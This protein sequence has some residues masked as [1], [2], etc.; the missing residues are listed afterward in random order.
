MEELIAKIEEI[1][2][3]IKSIDFGSANL[4][5]IT[6]LLFYGGKFIEIYKT[7][8]INAI[9]RPYMDRIEEYLLSRYE[10]INV[11]DFM[12]KK[13]KLISEPDL[14]IEFYLSRIESIIRD[15]YAER[16][17][18]YRSKFN[19]LKAIN[20]LYPKAS[21][22]TL[23]D[24]FKILMEDQLND[25]LTIQTKSILAYFIYMEHIEIIFESI[26]VHYGDFIN[27][28]DM[29]EIMENLRLK[30]R[31]H[32]FLREIQKKIV[33]NIQ[34]KIDNIDSSESVKE[35]CTNLKSK[36]NIEQFIKDFVLNTLNT[37]FSQ[38]QKVNEY[39]ENIDSEI[40]SFFESH[41]EF[42]EQSQPFF[43]KLESID[44]E[45]C[46]EADERAIAGENIDIIFPEICNLAIVKHKLDFSTFSKNMFLEYLMAEKSMV[47]FG[48]TLHKTEEALSKFFA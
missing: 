42:M 22:Q 1:V 45:I 34:S 24:S 28:S 39:F 20:D 27:R 32:T 38:K 17:Q 43:E 26:C 2:T 36:I 46:S 47:Q 37:P 29:E 9:F 4:L 25:Y 13:N 5:E 10:H 15:Q 7:Q 8:I 16:I 18:N 11:S 31:E 44:D 23:L 35:R 19:R 3:R 14:D 6:A 33:E 41:P 21:T 12:E 48:L 40:D 30:K